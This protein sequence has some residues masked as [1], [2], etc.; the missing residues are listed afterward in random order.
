M[1]ATDS[2]EPEA[3]GQE[4]AR[5]TGKGSTHDHREDPGQR[6][7]AA[8]RSASAARP[9]PAQSR[10][11]RDGGHREGTSGHAPAGPHHQPRPHRCRR[12]LRGPHPPGRGRHLRLP[13][14]RDPAALRRLG[15]LPRAAHH[16]RPPRA[17]SRTCCRRLR[18]CQRTRGRLPGHVRPRC[19]QPR[20]RHRHGPARLGAD[21][22]AHGQRARR[23]PGQGRLPGDRHQRHHPAH[24]QAQLPRAQR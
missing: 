22:R 10:F 11:R 7:R 17:G 13:R 19:H 16:P 6:G 23:A 2:D 9:A 15:R 3:D 4:R 5:S 21:G 1:S 8:G 20:H 14:R 24:D 18:S 12:A